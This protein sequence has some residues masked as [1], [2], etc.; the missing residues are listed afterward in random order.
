MMR[1]IATGSRGRIGTRFIKKLLKSD[2]NE[3]IPFHSKNF[4]PETFSELLKMYPEHQVLHLGWPASSLENY[5]SSGENMSA[6]KTA[7]AIG[8]MCS[9]FS[10]DLY[11]VGS[12]VETSSADTPYAQAKRQV[13]SYHRKSI[14][15]ARFGW[16]RPFFV[17]E[18][19]KWPE[20]LK[21]TA[22]QGQLDNLLRDYVHIEDVTEAIVTILSHRLKGIVE[23][24]SGFL[25]SQGNLIS[26]VLEENT[27]ARETRASELG[28]PADLE[29]LTE[30]GWAPVWTLDY[31]EK[32]KN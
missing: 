17:F 28:R 12:I 21:S 18:P 4:D 24:G 11:M 20:V 32:G 9:K 10:S 14:E 2:E 23:V 26:G 7:I 3:V 19:G 5:S 8:D 15:E 6:A 1:I 22:S 30:A 27:S 13:L 16:I 25:T 29:K 31:F